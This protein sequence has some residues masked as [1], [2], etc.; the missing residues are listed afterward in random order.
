MAFLVK[1]RKELMRIPIRMSPKS[2]Q[3]KPKFIFIK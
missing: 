1:K 3:L 2:P